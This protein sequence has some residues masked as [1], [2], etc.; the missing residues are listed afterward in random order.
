MNCECDAIYSEDPNT[1]VACKVCNIL[2]VTEICNTTAA[3]EDS[4]Y[5]C[6]APVLLKGS[7]GKITK[8]DLYVN[9]GLSGECGGLGVQCRADYHL[10]PHSCCLPPHSRC[11]SALVCFGE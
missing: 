3:L 9:C 2:Q 10:P 7:K 1:A 6:T 11:C 5:S 8:P 4:A